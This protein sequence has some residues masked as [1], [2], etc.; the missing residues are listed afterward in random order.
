MKRVSIN[1]PVVSFDHTLKACPRK[2]EWDRRS[3]EINTLTEWLGPFPERCEHALPILLHLGTVH[4]I[5]TV[6]IVIGQDI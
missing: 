1:G 3:N 4:P 6:S 5:S 2:N